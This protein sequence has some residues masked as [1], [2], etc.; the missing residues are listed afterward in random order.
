MK[1]KYF[2]GIISIVIEMDNEEGFN[3]YGLMQDIQR[4]LN[5]YVQSFEYSEDGVKAYGDGI[6]QIRDDIKYVQK[7]IKNKKR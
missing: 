1:T 6:T 7:R 2:D 4:E 3:D 5:R